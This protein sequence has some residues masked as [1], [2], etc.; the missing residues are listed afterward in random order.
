MDDH[1]D[2]F[3]QY[4]L[5]HELFLCG[6]DKSDHNQ[7]IHYKIEGKESASLTLRVYVSKPFELYLFAIAAPSEFERS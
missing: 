7:K 3:A 6:I 2:N 4:L 5:S 1:G